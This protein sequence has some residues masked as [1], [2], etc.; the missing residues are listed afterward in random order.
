MTYARIKNGII[1]NIEEISDTYT[2]QQ[3]QDTFGMG[4]LLLPLPTG[5]SIGDS[6]NPENQQWT[7]KSEEPAPIENIREIKYAEFDSACSD[8][9]TAGINV[10]TSQGKRHFDLSVID[11]NNIR[12]AMDTIRDAHAD[13]T[14]LPLIED[15][16]PFKASDGECLFYTEMDIRRLDLRKKAH[17][18]YNRTYLSALFAWCNTLSDDKVSEIIYGDYL[19]IKYQQHVDDV[20]SPLQGLI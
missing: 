13:E 15:G 6:Y 3:A 4:F 8:A 20:M 19:P 5:F 7:K 12:E 17:I 1:D 14:F 11:Q 16:I 10:E 9:I 2:L 18:L